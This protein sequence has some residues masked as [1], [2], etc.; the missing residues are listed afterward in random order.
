MAEA[1]IDVA[2]IC[3]LLYRRFVIG[4]RPF[5]LSCSK[6]SSCSVVLEVNGRKK[7]QGARK[8]NAWPIV[9]NLVWILSFERTAPAAA[10]TSRTPSERFRAFVSQLSTINRLASVICP[11]RRTNLL[12]IRGH[13]CI[14]HT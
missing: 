12:V 4:R 10:P 14:L 9:P 6:Y 7:G 5:W 2:Q 1:A 11:A 3:N 13:L 8:K